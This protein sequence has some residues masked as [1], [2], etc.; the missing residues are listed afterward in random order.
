[1]RRGQSSREDPKRRDGEMRWWI[2]QPI[3]E[4]RGK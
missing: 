4:T 2:E 1:M 3:R